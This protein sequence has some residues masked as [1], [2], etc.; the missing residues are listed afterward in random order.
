M[1]RVKT[2][3][4]LLPGHC[5]KCQLPSDKKKTEERLR[6]KSKKNLE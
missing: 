5:I 4:P 2:R 3:V 1:K 6:E